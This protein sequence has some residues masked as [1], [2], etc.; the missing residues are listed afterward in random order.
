M[1]DEVPK[2]SP[3][4]AIIAEEE[5]LFGQVSARI[6]L[7]EEE[8]EVRPSVGTE[9][10]DRDLLSLRD[11]ISEAKPEDLAPLVEQMTRLAALRGRLGG[12]KS[13]PADINS[14]YFAHMRLRERG[15]NGDVKRRDDA[16]AYVAGWEYA[17]L[18]DKAPIL[19]KEPLV[20]EEIHMS[21]RSYK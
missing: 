6:A 8:I 3:G 9:D 17:G 16:F 2:D 7:G 18:P 4:A 5:R 14:P 19:N 12:S 1:A 20:Y 11:Q 15:Q 13:L 21:T 10:I